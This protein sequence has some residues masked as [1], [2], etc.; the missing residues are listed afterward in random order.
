MNL[1]FTNCN[2]LTNESIQNIINMCLNSNINNANKNL[3]NINSYSPLYSTKF[4]NSYY[5]NRLSELT[6]AGW[7]Y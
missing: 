4:D 2:N 1:M 7:I 3:S 5:S 6:A